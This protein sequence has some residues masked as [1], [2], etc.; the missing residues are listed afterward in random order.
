MDFVNSSDLSED[1]K[2]LWQIVMQ[3]ASEDDVQALLDSIEGD[4]DHLRVLTE[5]MKLKM[6][7]IDS[8]D[9]DLVKDILKQEKEDIDSSEL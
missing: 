9:E 8:Q 4:P 3:M 2:E 6:K 7:A 5:N 1:D